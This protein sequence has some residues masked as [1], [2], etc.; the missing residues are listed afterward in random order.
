MNN[1][2]IYGIIVAIPIIL[3]INA[4][5]AKSPKVDRKKAGAIGQI[6]CV[7]TIVWFI[8]IGYSVY[9][10]VEESDDYS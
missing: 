2:L 3:I 4:N 5:I 9:S 10:C 7:L 6:G 8:A 1:Y